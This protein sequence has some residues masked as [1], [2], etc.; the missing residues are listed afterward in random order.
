[1]AD[2][3]CIPRAKHRQN[4]LPGELGAALAPPPT[5]GSS[6]QTRGAE[7]LPLPSLSHH[8]EKMER[9]KRGEAA[10]R[11]LGAPR[12]AGGQRDTPPT[13]PRHGQHRPDTRPCHPA[14]L[15]RGRAALVATAHP[16]THP[17]VHTRRG[18]ADPMVVLLYPH[19]EERGEQPGRAGGGQAAFGVIL[20]FPP[21]RLPHHA[22]AQPGMRQIF[23]PPCEDA[24]NIP[25]GATRSP[26]ARP[27][28]CVSAAA[29]AGLGGEGERWESSPQHPSS[30]PIALPGLAGKG[31]P[32]PGSIQPSSVSKT[33]CL[34]HN[35]ATTGLKQPSAQ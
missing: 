9:T 13:P 1:M 21:H 19:P 26:A 35:A 4:Q 8:G 24:E 18:G 15:A 27:A 32:E 16:H 25:A 14:G 29:G 3:G 30:S 17:C 22:R 23:P 33:S 10:G 11:R 31:N 34:M 20:S 6:G 28:L 12:G 2:A 5:P 7:A